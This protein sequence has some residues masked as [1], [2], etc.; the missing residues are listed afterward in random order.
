MSTFGLWRL[1]TERQTCER[2]LGIAFRLGHICKQKHA[3]GTKG[4]DKSTPCPLPKTRLED[5]LQLHAD[6]SGKEKSLG[7]RRR[8]FAAGCLAVCTPLPDVAASAARRLLQAEQH[9]PNLPN[10]YRRLRGGWTCE[11]GRIMKTSHQ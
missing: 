5:T 6:E 9:M 1:R 8:L 2:L 11:I 7:A 10:K 4:L 3:C